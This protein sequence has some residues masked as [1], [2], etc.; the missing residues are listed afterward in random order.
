MTG[1]LNT[2][3]ITAG[4]SVV[5]SGT[6]LLSKAMRVGAPTLDPTHFRVRGLGFRA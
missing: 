2:Q 3:D 5:V 1:P 6:W 4:L